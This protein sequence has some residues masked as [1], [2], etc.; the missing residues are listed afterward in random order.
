MRFGF[1]WPPLRDVK[2]DLADLVWLQ[3]IKDGNPA[4]YRWIEE[5]CGTAAAVSLGTARV[6]G[7]EK[8]RELGALHA[9]VPE[10]HFDDLMY[11]Y[12]F[13]EQLPGVELDHSPAGRKFKIFEQVDDQSRDE[14]IRKKR[15]A[16]PDHYRLYFALS[17]P[18]HALTQDNLTSMWIAAGTGAHEA[19]VAL[20]KL[21]DERVSGSLTKADLLLER[22]KSG[23]Y[24]V[25]APGHCENLLVAL[26][27]VMDEASRRQ[28]FDQFWVNSL[29]D[30][31]QRLIPLLLARLDPARRRVVVTAMFR[32]GA[33]VGWLTSLFRRETFSHGR[34]G[35]RPR[36]EEDWLFTDDEFDLIT[37]LM[38]NRYRAMSPSDV[39]GCPSPI[40]LLFAWRQG[41]DEDGPRRLLAESVVTD[42]GLIETLERLTSTITSSNRGRFDVLKKDN[43]A[44]FVDYDAVRKRIESL[45]SHDKLGARANPLL[46]AFN[47]GDRY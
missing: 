36:P 12:N 14:A 11:Q 23:A 10:G 42:E 28:P 9:T 4:L 24:E 34:Y 26:S 46:I 21:H 44:P 22:I 37:E 27:Q 6:E 39:F 38:L 3:L 25:L 41:G 20:L 47:D 45:S 40:D 29:W 15:L 8:A 13:A 19:G 1:F 18:S 33:A 2:A 31:G 7:A 35:E 5:Y 43:L 17:G 32:Q 16:S 30:A